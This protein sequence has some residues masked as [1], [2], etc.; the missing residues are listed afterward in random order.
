MTAL[1]IPWYL[2]KY[3][4]YRN[5]WYLLDLSASQLQLDVQHISVAQIVW[6]LEVEA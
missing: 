5:H 3:L 6:I 2:Q 4:D 1:L